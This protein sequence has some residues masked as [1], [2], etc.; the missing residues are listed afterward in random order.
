MLVRSRDDALFYA[1]LPPAPPIARNR[2]RRLKVL[3]C[4][5]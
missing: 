1:I 5:D 3:D 2:L 4:S